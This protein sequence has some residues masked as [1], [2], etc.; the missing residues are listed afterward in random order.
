[1]EIQK[2]QR[3]IIDGLEDVKVQ[4][5]KVFNTTHLIALDRVIVA[6]GTSNRQTKALANSVREKVKEQ[7]G[8]IVSTEGEES[9][10]GARLRRRCRA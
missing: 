8:D 4:D 1:M 2:L 5:I 7:G 10:N 3:A 6:S 9:A